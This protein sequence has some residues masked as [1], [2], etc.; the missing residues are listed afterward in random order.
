MSGGCFCGAG[1]PSKPWHF[2][3]IFHGVLPCDTG[4]LDVL[5]RERLV[6]LGEHLWVDIPLL[7]KRWVEI[8][9]MLPFK[10]SWIDEFPFFLV[11]HGSC[12]E[13]FVE[14]YDTWMSQEV[15]KW[16]VNY[17]YI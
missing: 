5:A 15:S 7:K 3:G 13:C 9:D 8:L 17:S 11:G 16:L 6:C 4:I 12:C 14:V 2:R 1:T 10:A